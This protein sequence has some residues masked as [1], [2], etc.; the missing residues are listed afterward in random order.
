LCSSPPP[1][2]PPPSLFF[3]KEVL[4]LFVMP[5]V[6]PRNKV[7][8][9][10][11]TVSNRVLSDNTA[12][13]IYGNVNYAKTFL[14]GTVINVFDLDR[15]TPGGKNVVWKLT[16]DFKMHSEEPM[17][18]VELKNV[19]VHRQH[20]T[21]GPVPSGELNQLARAGAIFDCLRISVASLSPCNCLAVASSFRPPLSSSRPPSP[22]D[23]NGDGDGDGDGDCHWRHCRRFL[24]PYCCHHRC[25]SSRYPLRRSRPSTLSSLPSQGPRQRR[26]CR[27]RCR[28]RGRSGPAALSLPPSGATDP[29]AAATTKTLNVPRRQLQRRRRQRQWQQRR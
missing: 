26:S 23:E 8:A 12:K 9:I 21:L 4:S 27:Q 1:P 11:H 7:G 24:Y 25:R 29:T 15:R 6:D 19:A 10:V 20:C 17:L 14:Q 16:V 22:P 2:R 28:H 5:K 13:N 18:G 3:S